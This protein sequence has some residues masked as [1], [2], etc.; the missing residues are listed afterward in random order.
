FTAVLHT[1]LT[2]MQ[3]SD[4]SGTELNRQLEQQYTMS[5]TH[6]QYMFELVEQFNAAYKERAAA[7]A[8]QAAELFEEAERTA[9]AVGVTALLLAAAIAVL[10]IRSF[11]LPIRR[12]RQAMER[13]GEGDLRHRIRS[14]HRDE[15]GKLAGSFDRMI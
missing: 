5:L 6:Q 9:V 11:L 3:A 12:M 13:I 4:L 14:P 2:T 10:L 15:L 1:A 7:A 8:M